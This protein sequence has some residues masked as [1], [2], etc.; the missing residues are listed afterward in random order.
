VDRK[1]NHPKG[2]WRRGLELKGPIML[3]T[4]VAAMALLGVYFLLPSKAANDGTWASGSTYF[5]DQAAFG[6]WRGEPTTIF[7]CWADSRTSAAVQA[8]PD[9]IKGAGSWTGDID[10]AVGM[11]T[12]GESISAAASGAYEARWRSMVTGIRANWGNK[13]TIYIRPAHEFNGNWF[14]WSVTPSNV[15]QWK[16]AWIRYH[17]IIKTELKDKGYNAKVVLSYNWDSHNSGVSVDT[18]WPGDQYVDVV[19][20][21]KYDVWWGT[22]PPTTINTLARWNEDLGRTDHSGNMGLNEWKKFATSH[23]KPLGFP[24][25][26]LSDKTAGDNPFWIQQ[27]HSWF[28]ANAGSGPG[29]VLYE[30]YFNISGY[31]ATKLY[32]NPESPNAAEKYRSLVWGKGGTVNPTPTPPPP[33]PTPPPPTPP[34]PPSPTPNPPASKSPDVNGDTK[35]NLVDLSMLLSQWNGSGSA[36]LNNNGKVDLTDISMLLSAWKP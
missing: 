4:I 19:G 29:Q 26:G 34:T 36:D 23:G 20:V 11:I 18:V 24:E 25:W 3:A 33:T 22:N 10:L 2:L 15:N 16:Q 28:A 32:P 12:N 35:V 8:T 13:R 14:P 30:V 7:G 5:Q 21:D 1:L 27:M 9:C 31:G 6:A 17:N